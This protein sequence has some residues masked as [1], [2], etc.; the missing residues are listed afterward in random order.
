MIGKKSYKRSK[1]LHRKIDKVGKRKFS[2]M[3]K[4]NE[5]NYKNL[6]KY[7]Y[8]ILKHSR[9]GQYLFLNIR[10]EA[11]YFVDISTV[12]P[13]EI[14]LYGE[15]E[16]ILVSKSK[17]Q[18]N[19]SKLRTHQQNGTKITLPFYTSL[20]ELKQRQQET[21][22][23][24]RHVY[25][26]Y[27]NNPYELEVIYCYLFIDGRTTEGKQIFAPLF[28]I[29]IEL[30]YEESKSSFLIRLAS[31]ELRLNTFALV[32][33]YPKKEKESALF[34][35]T[36]GIRCPELPL[37]LESVN[38]VIKK[39]TDL[40]PV[41][42]CNILDTTDYSRKITRNLEVNNFFI[43]NTAGLC[44]VKKD[45]VYLINDLRTL[46]E[47][48]DLGLAFSVLKR[49]VE[50]NYN[51]NDTEDIHKI[52]EKI[53][54][55]PFP[56]NPS[57][58]KVIKEINNNQLIH[59]QGPPGTGKS[60]TIA[61]LIC[62]LVANG[63]TVLV[64]SQK[65]KALE[66]VSEMLNR[67]G[68]K[69]LYMMLLKDD[70]ESKKK[71]KEIINELLSEIT[72]YNLKQLEDTLNQIKERLNECDEELSKL[73]K[74]FIQTQNFESQKVG[75][76]DLSIG[77]IYA[78][79]E[80]LKPWDLFEEDE[81]IRP[82][83]KLFITGNLK[84]Y[85]IELEKILPDYIILERFSIGENIPNSSNEIDLFL[86][87]LEN[88]KLLFE[89]EVSLISYE[90]VDELIKILPCFFD[91]KNLPDLISKI[92]KLKFQ[93]QHYISY[94]NLI[95][96]SQT[97][98]FGKIIN[99]L[100]RIPKS[101]FIQEKLRPKL[102]ALFG[103]WL[104]INDCVPEK[105]GEM[106]SKLEAILSVVSVLDIRK[107]VEN[108]IATLQLRFVYDII[109]C[110]NKNCKQKLRIP[111]DKGKII[112]R[113]PKCKTEFS[114]SA[115][116]V[117]DEMLTFNCLKWQ[118]YTCYINKNYDLFN[119]V[120]EKLKDRLILYPTFMKL[121]EIEAHLK[122]YKKTV[123]KL[124]SICLLENKKINEFIENIE[125][126]V[127][128]GVLRGIIKENDREFPSTDSIATNI[129][130]VYDDK[131]KFIRNFIDAAIKHNL[132]NKLID[133]ILRNDLVYFA[134]I[135][136]RSKK[137]YTTFEQLKE[138]IDFK[139]ILTA[140]PCWIM[141]IYD[142]ARIFPLKP[143]LF[144]VVIVDESSQCAIP[145]AIP[146]L[147]RGKKA[148]IV[149]DDQQLPNV[150][151]QYVDDQF[152]K[153][154]IQEYKLYELPRP[155]SFDCKTNSL[156][157]L[158][159]NFSDSHIF[160]NEHF[161]CYPEIIRFCNEKF[162]NNRLLLAK[163]SFVNNLGKILN[164]EIV[165][166][167][168]DD[169]SLSV[170]KKESEAV[171]TKLKTL[172]NDS[173]YQGLTFGVMSIFREQVEYMKDLIFNPDSG[174][175]I[176]PQ[177]RQ[178]YHLIVE[179]AD[180]FQGDERDI[181]IYS[182]RF[183]PNSSPHILAHTRRE[184]DYKRLNVAFSRARCQI[185]C[186]VSLSP[187]DFPR[188]ILR[189]YLLYVQNPKSLDIEYQPWDSEFE[190][191]VQTE[192]EKFGLKVYPQFKSCGFRIDLVV[193]NE[194][195]K[196]LAVE[197]DGWQY[198]YDEFGKLNLEDIERQHILERSGWKVIRICSRD[199]YRNRNKAL[200]P[201]FDFFKTLN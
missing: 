174:F 48:E 36:G 148:I 200:R 192:I 93:L 62:H 107:Q 63:Y 105:E 40:H 161:R 24:L 167:A 166:N 59:V 188:G 190:K 25:D 75:G 108:L 77:E 15:D 128:A 123:S 88:L 20:E 168:Y 39:I 7:C 165:D 76:L 85:F 22:E 135:L 189:D 153:S 122:D 21:L 12:M 181:I 65:N 96:E 106:I 103:K 163:S 155:Q 154:L 26:Y 14:L 114:F 187:A 54:L 110:Q 92:I 90:V 27:T 118:L 81:F 42:K 61:N 43:S 37:T 71:I 109:L 32:D 182:F 74:K 84:N 173:K 176:D 98:S 94:K 143:G 97:S 119:E 83:D 195:N 95:N 91:M 104:K 47:L 160:L 44:L 4:E 130:R 172:L 82:S 86:E 30:T 126:I 117:K 157:D 183:A 185:F 89:K 141:S 132:R 18:R 121:R 13:N 177:T 23:N 70:K 34:S 5:L 194:K 111:L 99:K 6:I 28:T 156:F 10:D 171:I 2:D 116:E 19:F 67:L 137:K 198:H 41:I 11:K 124:K 164:L 8:E 170:N 79:Y 78:Q 150:E 49:F 199:F 175:Y 138:E 57:Q 142:V 80:K 16:K 152:N 64:T 127:D 180:G 169:E 17:N 87:G 73:H 201:V 3:K 145:S 158:C 193:T 112:V 100:W 68:L 9:H 58:I 131:N 151:M 56:A 50:K 149:G 140:I 53:L 45:N 33:L 120:F 178:K 134:R 139:A 1:I 146:I 179:T 66:V 147:Y 136:Q 129:R 38:Q 69:Y 191:E 55:N 46:L 35:R 115:E 125:R 31:D 186:F 51:H 72:S 162:Y 159:A 113:C 101:L 197:C 144:D 196:V 52:S 60:Q 29:P 102:N 184:E 133:P